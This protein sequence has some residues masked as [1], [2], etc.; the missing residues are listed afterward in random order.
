MLSV[1]SPFKR[2][3]LYVGGGAALGLFLLF[4]GYLVY[5]DQVV[6]QKFEGQRW[7]LPSKI[8]STPFRITPEMDVDANALFSRLNHLGYYRV[9]HPVQRAGEFNRTD[10]GL[11]IYLHDFPY[12]GRPFS[13][14]PVVLMLDG[15]K[16]ISRIIDLTL[17]EEL[18]SVEIEPELISGLYEGDWQ[19][20]TLIHLS[21][22]SPYLVHAV[23]AA[24]DHRFFEHPGFD[25]RGM[26]RA[27]FEDIRHGQVVQGGSTLTQ[28]LV[29]NFYLTSRRTLSR[30][31]NEV[32]MSLL[33]ERRYSK[34]AILEA[35]L[36]E[37]Y[38]GQNGV[39]G[40]YGMGEG[41]WFYFGKPPAELN[42]AESALL[43]GL[44]RSPN[45]LSPYKDPKKAI[46]RRNMVLER[47]F[48]DGTITLREYI[49]ARGEAVPSNRLRERTNGAPYFIDE[50]RQQLN[51]QYP[52]ELLVSGG[53]RIFTTLDMEMQRAAEESIGKGLKALEQRYSRLRR[54][55]PEKQMEG[56]L[57]AIDQKSGAVRA[58]VGGRDYR[59]T[60]YNRITQARRQPG[61]LFKP[62]VYLTAFSE[63]ERGEGHLTP[64]SVVDDEPLT[65][66]G[67][68]SDGKD[69]SPQNYDRSYHGPVTLR[70]A[71]EN[72]LNV[73]TVRV[74]QEVGAEKVIET[75]RLLG[76]RSP[77]KNVPSLALGTSEITPIEISAA[78]ATIA[79]EGVQVTPYLIEEVVNNAGDVLDQHHPDFPAVSQVVSPQAAYLVNYLLQ[80]VVEHGTGQGVRRLSFLRP[81]AAKTGTTSDERDAWFLGYTPDLLATVWVG[82]DDNAPLHLTGSTAALPIWTAFMKRALAGVPPSDFTPPP[83]IVF[84]RIDPTTGLRC[85]QGIDEAFLEGTEPNDLCAGEY[86]SFFDRLR[87]IF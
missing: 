39:M 71:L 33:L 44:I 6:V 50:V 69:W 81:A 11:E 74:L 8:Y 70:A 84:R 62:F 78:Y 35:Y 17:A 85:S 55:E 68:R 40:I 54:S 76:I 10:D 41:S 79:N 25:W 59:I 61:S 4:L 77:L 57:V 27:L 23:I 7:K 16:V 80:G 87:D 15:G 1:S 21:D 20:R 26:A 82:F 65:V 34:E 73:A 83:K 51:E 52:R 72:S 30:K 2:R 5:L 48:N 32:L 18:P 46:A 36:N 56:A 3:L 37:I 42:L 75:A 58:M 45:T 47:L 49:R 38:L 66:E 29:K 19:E 53:L 12:P 22:L 60:Q 43:A 63:A 13:G 28:Q 9:F 14:F 64:A 67:G 86:P 24:E 31:V